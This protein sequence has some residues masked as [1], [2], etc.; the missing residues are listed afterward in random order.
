MIVFCVGVNAYLAITA[1]F[2]SGLVSLSEY[3]NLVDLGFSLSFFAALS[4]PASSLVGGGASG[5]VAVGAVTVAAALVSACF[6][7]VAIK[8]SSDDGCWLSSTVG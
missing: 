6:E 2:S 3:T 1:I 8:S 7:A 5:G 4:S